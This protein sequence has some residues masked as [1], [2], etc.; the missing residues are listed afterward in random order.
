MAP[1]KKTAWL[2]PNVR[3]RSQHRVN[4]P[5]GHGDLHFGGGDAPTHGVEV[6]DCGRGLHLVHNVPLHARGRARP[7]PPPKPGE[8]KV[9]NRSAAGRGGRGPDK[10][11]VDGLR[12]STS[13]MESWMLEVAAAAGSEV[14]S[15]AETHHGH[16]S[17][18]PGK[19]WGSAV[20]AAWK[21]K[22]NKLH[23]SCP[24]SP[25]VH[26]RGWDWASMWFVS[27]QR[28]EPQNWCFWDFNSSE[29]RV[30]LFLSL[31]S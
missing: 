29:T 31:F 10:P 26:M 30:P 4:S 19:D 23:P 1:K 14:G 9:E 15:H 20:W 8:P 2:S 3:A 28:A 11:P 18:S 17:C 13:S 22:R 6:T 25:T 24:H 12:W 27:T 7:A 16:L 21:S 5:A